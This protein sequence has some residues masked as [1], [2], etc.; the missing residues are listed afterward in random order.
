MER[1]SQNAQLMFDQL[2]YF[3]TVPWKSGLTN[4]CTMVQDSTINWWLTG[5]CA[6]CIRGIEINPHDIDIMIDSQSIAETTEIFKDYLIEPIVSTDG[7]VTKDFGVLFMDVRIDIASDP[8]PRL[9]EPEPADCGPYALKHLEVIEW[10]NVQIKVP[11]LDLQ[12]RVNKKRG[13]EDRV[14]KIEEFLTDRD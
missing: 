10:N 11:P 6:T 13:R 2:G 12:L 9:D 5:S 14:K 4:F 1:Y 8:T 7:W 3:S